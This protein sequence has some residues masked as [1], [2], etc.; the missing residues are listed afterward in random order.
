MLAGG[1]SPERDISLASGHAVAT[2]M[3]ELGEEVREIDPAEIPVSKCDWMAGDV[4]L[5]A[6]HGPGG[7]DGTIQ[8]DLDSLGVPYTG[9]G[10]GVSRLAFSKSLS[11]IHI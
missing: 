3:R 6:L 4:V 9:C 7:E 2:A 10:V 8:A 5:L 1:D 11:L